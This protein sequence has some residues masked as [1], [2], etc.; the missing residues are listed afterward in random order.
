MPT[1]DQLIIEAQVR[2]T[3]V[4][5]VYTGLPVRIVLTAFPARS[6]PELMGVVDQ[7]S[8]DAQPNE[9]TGEPFYI[10]QVS[11]SQEEL[12]KLDPSLTLLPGMPVELFVEGGQRTAIQYLTAPITDVV[13]R[14][15][16]E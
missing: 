11:V 2:T 7:V 13:R 10:A 8:A 3:D 4:D 15:L 16:T 6:T 12:D 5:S 1:D 14:S 9:I